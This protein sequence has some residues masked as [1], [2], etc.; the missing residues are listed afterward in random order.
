MNQDGSKPQGGQTDADLDE[1][2]RRAN[3]EAEDRV[4]RLANK[5]K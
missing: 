5:N 3:K 2:L 1:I 4:K